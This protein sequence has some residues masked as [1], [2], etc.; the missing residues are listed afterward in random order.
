MVR[1]PSTTFTVPHSDFS[2]AVL[3]GDAAYLPVGVE[4]FW[5]SEIVGAELSCSGVLRSAS[6]G[7]TVNDVVVTI[8][9]TAVREL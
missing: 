5:C 2:A 3:P 8:C 9:A 6:G 4:E 1:S 7:V